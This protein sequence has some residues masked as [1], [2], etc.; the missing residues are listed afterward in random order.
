M[1]GQFDELGVRAAHVA[2]LRGAEFGKVGLYVSTTLHS[3]TRRGR[4][5]QLTY[6]HVKTQYWVFPAR[7]LQAGDLCLQLVVGTVRL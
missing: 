7:P 5:F 1:L 2:E 3:E 4:A 6:M